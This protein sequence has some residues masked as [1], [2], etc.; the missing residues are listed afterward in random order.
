VNL[1]T[2]LRE[3]HV[4]AKVTENCVV[5]CHYGQVTVLKMKA[6]DHSET[7]RFTK[8]HLMSQISCAL[9]VTVFGEF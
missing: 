8:L 4:L 7:F 9:K 3:C 1:D 6:A 5:L 2:S